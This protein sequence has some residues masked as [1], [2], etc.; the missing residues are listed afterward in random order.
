[1]KARDLMRPA[2][3]VEPEDDARNLFPAFE[4]PEIRAVAVVTKVVTAVSIAVSAGYIYLRYF[5]PG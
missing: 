2:L 3:V 4:D 5:W 1:M